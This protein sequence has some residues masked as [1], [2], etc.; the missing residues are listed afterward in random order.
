[1]SLSCVANPW[2]KRRVLAGSL[3]CSMYNSIDIVKRVYT[4]SV[5]RP[6][7]KYL[8][9][10]VLLPNTLSLGWHFSLVR[11]HVAVSAYIVILVVS[12]LAW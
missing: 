7:A 11:L 2:A 4:H 5:F 9:Y 3:A 10:I 1:M 6:I 8:K 12:Y